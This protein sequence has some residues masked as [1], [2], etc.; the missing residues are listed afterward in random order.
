MLGE[1]CW[2]DQEPSDLLI[3]GLFGWKIAMLENTARRWRSYI[4]TY[5]A[6]APK[7]EKCLRGG[8]TRTIIMVGRLFTIISLL[9]CILGIQ[10]DEFTVFRTSTR[11]ISHDCVHCVSLVCLV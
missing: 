2:V 11:D 1:A 5:F 4:T 10:E 3:F 8:R 6:T 7:D 9:G